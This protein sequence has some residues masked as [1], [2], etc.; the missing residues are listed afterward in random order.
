MASTSTQ[1]VPVSEPQVEEIETAYPLPQPD[2]KEIAF[3][4]KLGSPIPG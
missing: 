3:I 4:I 2:R 1:T